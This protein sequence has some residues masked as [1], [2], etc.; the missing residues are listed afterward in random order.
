[1]RLF[2]YA[3]AVAL[4]CLPLAAKD[5]K[6]K[7]VERLDDAASL[8]S[9]IMATPDKS[10]PQG[11]LDKAACIVLVPGL[12]KGAFVIGGKYGR[13]FALCHSGSGE[14][15]GPP[16]AVDIEGGSFGLQV[17]FASSD[18]VLLIMNERGMKRL[19]SSKFTIGGEAT[20]AAGPVGRDATAQTDALL[21]AEILSWSRS[22]GLFAGISL[23][24]A[25]LRSDIAEN[26]A[27]YG[28][29]WDNKQILT[30]GA[31]PP[32]E[33]SKLIA[34]LNKYSPRQTH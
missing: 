1:M 10:I 6:A 7:A 17:G 21:T 11:L 2:T 30:S 3:L 4:G 20:A 13:G 22:R 32:A 29:R 14:G 16:A 27:L 15:W 28:Q 19:T 18:V 31:Q 9:E 8:F 24:G 33:A 26:Q 25:T 34:L 5:E 23:D 12:K